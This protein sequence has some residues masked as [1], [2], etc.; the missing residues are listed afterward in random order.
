MDKSKSL[1]ELEGVDEGDPEGA[2][3]NMVRR[4]LEL[5]RTPL[6]QW[7]AEDCRLMLGQKFSPQFLVPIALKF[8][9]DDPLESGEMYSGALLNNVLKVPGDFWVN[10]SELWWKVNEIVTEVEFQK[11]AIEELEPEIENFKKWEAK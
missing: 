10:H 4:C 8:L 2:P 11:R 5:H 7:S 3:T 6:E 9:A 1:Q